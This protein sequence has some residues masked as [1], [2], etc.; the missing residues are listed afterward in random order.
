MNIDDCSESEKKLNIGTYN[1]LA[2]ICTKKN[3]EQFYMKCVLKMES[4]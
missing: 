3:E 1:F 2:L 4:K